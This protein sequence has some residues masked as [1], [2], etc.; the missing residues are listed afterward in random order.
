[1]KNTEKYIGL[2]I[3]GRA[4][5]SEISQDLNAISRDHIRSDL[6]DYRRKLDHDEICVALAL[7]KEKS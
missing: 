6:L 7:L 2:L 3:K 5:F 1:M 4:L